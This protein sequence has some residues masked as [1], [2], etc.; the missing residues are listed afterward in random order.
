MITGEVKD[1]REAVVRLMLEGPGGRTRVVESVVDTGFTDYLTVT[2]DVVD[3]PGLRFRESM[4]F[5]LAD[6]QLGMF[7]L[8]ECSVWWHGSIRDVLVG[9]AQ[10]VSLVGMALLEG[11]RVE[12]DVVADGGVRIMQLG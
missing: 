11:S 10:G 12:I 6:G 5:E 4:A 3:A 7:D 8:Y 1:S 9:V 2:R